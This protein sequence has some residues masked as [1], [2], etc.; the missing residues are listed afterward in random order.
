VNRKRQ[1]LLDALRTPPEGWERVPETPGLT[2]RWGRDQ[3]F[4]DYMRHGAYANWD[5]TYRQLVFLTLVSAKAAPIMRVCRAPWVNCQDTEPSLERA[6]AVL[7][8]P[9]A[10]LE[11]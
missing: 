6:L 8:D 2:I 5:P 11:R 10:E 1:A 4:P 9:A 7:A 3:D